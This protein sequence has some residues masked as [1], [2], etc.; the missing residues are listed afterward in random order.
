MV[1][2]DVQTTEGRFLRL[3][4]DYG[5]RGEPVICKPKPNP[6]RPENFWYSGTIDDFFRGYTLSFFDAIPTDRR[7]TEILRCY[8][9]DPAYVVPQ[10]ILLPNAPTDKE[11]RRVL[12]QVTPRSEWSVVGE[13]IRSLDDI[14]ENYR[15][16]QLV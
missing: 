9:T 15:P 1:S 10:A 11:I 8:A 5:K 12:R 6:E 3:V 7:V 16:R 13:A 2:L 14:R 4:V